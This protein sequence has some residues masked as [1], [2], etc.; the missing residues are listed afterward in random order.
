MIIFTTILY[1]NS[2]IQLMVTPRTFSRIGR[3]RGR[4]IRVPLKL[5]M[6]ITLIVDFSY[7]WS[8]PMDMITHRYQERPSPIKVADHRKNQVCAGAAI[9]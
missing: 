6:K 1:S 9:D 5:T 2:L 4:K 8:L 3:G 7:G